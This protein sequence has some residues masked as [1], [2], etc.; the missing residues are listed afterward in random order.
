MYFKTNKGE[1]NQF[2]NKHKTWH[3]TD[4][5]GTIIVNCVPTTVILSVF[6]IQQA[7]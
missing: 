7:P 3:K 6:L 2:Y 5:S 4:S 1:V